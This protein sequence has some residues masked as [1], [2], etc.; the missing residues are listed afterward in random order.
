MSA[1]RFAALA[2]EA[3]RTAH[4][5]GRVVI[6]CGGTGLYARAF[7]GG[8]VEG[9]T[10]EPALRAELEAL[11][12]A[13][14]LERLR[15]LDP[16]LAQ[17]VHPNNHVRLVR[18]VE[19]ASLGGR[20]ASERHARHGFGDRPFDVAWLGLDLPREAL[21][22]RLRARVDAMFEAGWIDEV[23]R[24]R[25]AGHGPELKSMQAIGYRE[26]GAMLDAGVGEGEVREQI[27][28]ATRRYARRQR[29][30]F[31][32]EPGME[33]IDARERATALERALAGLD[34]GRPAG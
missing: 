23:R 34:P 7:A 19:I 29:T 14:L 32:S 20:A 31:R 5:R 26:I 22:P 25:A 21:W 1:G 8:L 28:W 13:Q 18:Y 17:R 9:V 12:A 15:E 3:A 6:L 24:L 30:W 33:W 27:W 10:G 11:P 2:R 16:D 4:A